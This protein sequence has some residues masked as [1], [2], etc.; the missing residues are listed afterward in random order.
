LAQTQ[1]FPVSEPHQNGAVPAP[2]PNPTLWLINRI[3]FRICMSGP[4]LHYKLQN[5]LKTHLYQVKPFHFWSRSCS[6][7][8]I[9]MCQFFI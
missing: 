1:H 8:R 4:I 5:T 6:R 2:T 7:S 3:I 9:K